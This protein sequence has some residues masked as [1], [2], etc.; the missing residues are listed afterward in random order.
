MS[1]FSPFSRYESGAASARVRDLLVRLR[2]RMRD[3]AIL[4][5]AVAR[6]ATGQD[7][8]PGEAAEQLARMA[9]HSGLELVE[10]AKGIERPPD[11]P[12]PAPDV[13]GWVTGMLEAVHAS[14]LY[15][16]PVHDATGR[17]VDFLI[18]AAN[19]HA[20]TVAGRTAADLAGH[21]LMAVLPG[22]AGSGLL[23]DYITVFEA[24]EPMHRDG[25]EY[26]EVLDYLLWP[27]TL[28]VRASRV[29]DGLLVSWRQLDDEELLVSGW[30]RAQRLAELG[31][32]EWNL[33][34]QR[35]LWTPQMYEMFGRDRADGPMALE[36]LLTVVVPED[37]PV[38]E[39]QV[40]SL[41]EYR[42]AVET[43]FRIQH[44][45][46]VRHLC[47]FG[48]PILDSD[49]VPVKVRCLAQDVTRSR[50]RERALAVAHEQAHRQRQRA[51]E[52]HRVTVQLQDTIVPIRRG[53]IHLPGLTVGVRYLPGEELV[54]LGGDWFK[55]RLLPDGRV[56]IAIGDAMGHGLTAASIMLQ[57]RSGL[58]G[59]A[60]TQAPAGQ[61]ATWL[62][63]LIVHS[64]ED[65]TV[66]GTA[67][68]GHFDPQDCTFRW[69]SAGHPSPVLIRNGRPEPI[70]GV[71]G[72]MLGAFDVTEYQMTT[73]QLQQGDVLLLYTDGIVE[74]RGQDLET[75]IQSLL[76]AAHLCADDDPE[77]MIDCLLNRLGGDLAEDDVCVLAV[78]VL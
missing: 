18:L 78:R 62:N 38:V 77:R 11:E 52:E 61:L 42:E 28:S 73:T 67:V 4:D 68:I 50:R 8:R 12:R 23:D 46:G 9:Q 41:L 49:G 74:R 5:E 48:E 35:T 29:D 44:R 31:W 22:V 25:V 17:V 24:G 21:R 65:V 66:T 56:L 14:A 60:Y 19:R 43:E 53:L 40:R 69:T 34:T 58:A 15:L 36:D 26:V 72:M 20:R 45:H 51:E 47:V 30:E 76:Q 59:L 13:P 39:E 75:G 27:A 6:L 55:A 16:T 63:D 2:M 71:Q 32:G 70:D 54:R 33:A 10:V 7:I 1:R 3:E 57:M 37:L 64:N